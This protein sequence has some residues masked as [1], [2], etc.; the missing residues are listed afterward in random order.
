MYP[1]M[2]E[3]VA[4]QRLKDLQLEMENSR[5]LA[6]GG[7]P[8]AVAWARRLAE[9]ARRL[10]GFLMSRPSRRQSEVDRE[11]AAERAAAS[12]AA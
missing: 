11:E 3:D 2:N 12:D 4:W 5:L 1:Y 10:G 8:A 9:R 6:T 7:V